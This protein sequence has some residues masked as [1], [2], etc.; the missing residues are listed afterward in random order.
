MPEGE[1]DA[2]GKHLS[3]TVLHYSHI[4]NWREGEREGER[5][6]ERRKKERER[7]TEKERMT[8]C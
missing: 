8:T 4:K 5:E 3:G 2:G 1:G 6:R 7:E